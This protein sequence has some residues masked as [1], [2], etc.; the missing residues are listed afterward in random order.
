LIRNVS[1]ELEHLRRRKMATRHHKVEAQEVQKRAAE[2]R[3]HWSPL[4]KLRRTGL[5][6]D[7]P[8]RLRQF[9]MSGSTADWTPA[10]CHVLAGGTPTR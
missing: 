3:R 8:A 6:P 2:I 9:I 5:P 7:V 10:L 4:E 1:L